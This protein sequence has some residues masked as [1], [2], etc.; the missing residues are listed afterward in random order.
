MTYAGEGANSLQAVE[1]LDTAAAAA[2]AADA[3]NGPRPAASGNPH[4][5]AIDPITLTPTW[6]PARGL[7]AA[8]CLAA[9]GCLRPG[10]RLGEAA[11]R[12]AHGRQLLGEGLAMLGVD[13]EVRVMVSTSLIKVCCQGQG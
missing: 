1:E 13:T 2:A 12:L 8:A 6:L 9:A 7:A 11:A 4:V 5:L 3:A 10:G